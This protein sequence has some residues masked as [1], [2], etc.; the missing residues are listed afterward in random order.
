LKRKI[1]FLRDAQGD[2]TS[3]VSIMIPAG[4]QLHPMRQKLRDEAGAASNIKSR[5]NRQSVEGALASASHKLS[6]YQ[7]TPIN[8]LCV[9][10]GTIID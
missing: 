10:A 7:R 5:V 3:M 2:G 6:Q 4:A 1:T 9:F 8:G